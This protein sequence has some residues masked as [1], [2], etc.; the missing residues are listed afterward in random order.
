MFSNV[1]ISA[2]YLSER[3]HFSLLTIGTIKKNHL[4]R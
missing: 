1:M 2:L 3:T 4:T